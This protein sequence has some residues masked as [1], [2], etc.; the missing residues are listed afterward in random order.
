MMRIAFLPKS[1]DDGFAGILQSLPALERSFRRKRNCGN[2]NFAALAAPYKFVMRT[3]EPKPHWN[4]YFA[5]VF[6]NPKLA[7]EGPQTRANFGFGTLAVF[8]KGLPSHCCHRNRAMFVNRRK[9]SS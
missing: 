4:Q 9:R 1:L 7:K 6:S 3:S 2:E 8:V 5:S